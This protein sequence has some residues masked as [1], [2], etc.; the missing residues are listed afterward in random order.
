[1]VR[2]TLLVVALLC[3]STAS[4]YTVR[5]EVEAAW[6]TWLTPHGVGVVAP[7]DTVALGGWNEFGIHLGL[8]W[9]FGDYHRW[10]LGPELRVGTALVTDTYYDP[11][12]GATVTGPGLAWRI[13]LGVRLERDMVYFWTRGSLFL[14]LWAGGGAALDPLGGHGPFV[15]DAAILGGL[16]WHTESR[17]AFSVVLSP[18]VVSAWY[19][20]IA[21]AEVA[22]RLD[23]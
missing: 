7:G 19:G 10:R 1:M 4:A 17:V 20:V 16:R 13:L 2:R 14:G 6:E 18:H 3:S 15:Y 9:A 23:F 11:A 21:T 5:A 12:T 8:L 22:L